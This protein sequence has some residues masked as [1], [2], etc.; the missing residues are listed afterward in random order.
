VTQQ[1]KPKIAIP[2]HFWWDQAPQ[3]FVQGMPKV[4]ALN[5]PILKISKAELPQP[6]EIVVMPWG[7]R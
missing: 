3:E 6:T 7:Q 2:M 1:I 4:K 5:T